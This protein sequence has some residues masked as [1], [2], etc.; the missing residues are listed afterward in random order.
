MKLFK[1]AMLPDPVRYMEIVRAALGRQFM[2][3]HDFRNSTTQ[4]A[5]EESFV[6]DSMAKAVKGIEFSELAENITLNNPLLIA[7]FSMRSRIQ[8]LDGIYSLLRGCNARVIVSFVPAG[9]DYVE[10]ARHR[11]ESAMSSEG[12][13]FTKS[14]RSRFGYEQSG[15]MQ[16]DLYYGSMERKAAES[17]LNMLNE[18]L[19]TNGS[20]Y[21][22]MII[23]DSEDNDCI[24]TAVRFIRSRVLVLEE[25]RLRVSRLDE[26]FAKVKSADA[27][28]FS[29]SLASQM[30]LFSDR[31]PQVQSVAT[32]KPS[33]F[34]GDITIGYFIEDAISKTEE[35][36]TTSRSTF[37][38]G[39]IIT[40]LPGYGKTK[41]AM[42]IVHQLRSG[43]LPSVIISPTDEWNEFASS[44]GM[45]VVK[46]Y[47]QSTPINFFSCPEG[48]TVEH[49]Y[50]NL[51]MLIAAAS[52]AG[53]YKNSLEKCLLSAFHKAYSDTRSPDPVTVYEEIEEAVVEQHG[54]RSNVG[55]KY[56][57]HGENVRA[58]LENL[59][60]VLSRPEF[61]SQ[62][63]VNFSELVNEGVLFDLSNVSN[64]M[65]PFFYALILNQVYGITDSLDSFGE[66]ELRMLVCI[67]EAQLAFGEQSSAA[68]ADLMQRIQDFRKRGIALILIAHSITE[69]DIG[70]RRLCQTKLYFRQSADIVRFA[71]A[72]LGFDEDQQAIASLRSLGQ[73]RCAVSY[74]SYENGE[75]RSF[76]SLFAEIP[77]ADD[78]T[79]HIKKAQNEQQCK[80]PKIIDCT[81]SLDGG[82]RS[83]AGAHVELQYLGEVKHSGTLDG[84]GSITFEKLIEGVNYTMLLHGERKKDTIAIKFT[85]TSYVAIKL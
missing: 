61:A 66:K 12:T 47:N 68:S 80:V 17:M 42:S 50:E 48:V 8:V 25:K 71:A 35:K 75:R 58:A 23:L 83:L 51:A 60:L 6:T 55:V 82:Q 43:S 36:I 45:H 28:P 26:L 19:F 37:N 63:G 5:V 74:V 65:K 27:V 4:I 31:I 81:V 46:L 3:I 54:K 18:S 15:S 30:V 41:A 29:L 76:N 85:A 21:K 69:I 1:I 62:R 2:M 34:A 33:P 24:E 20:A 78:S 40:G 44:E 77:K 38:L 57:K 59:R 67:E 79:I 9:K 70:I 73:R 72:D 13:R 52:N 14:F 32:K 49:F 64:A 53:P 11:L 39:T 56:T 22:L 16:M 7:F 84:S 10:H